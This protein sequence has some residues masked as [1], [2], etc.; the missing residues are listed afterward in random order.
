MFHV[1]G[2]IG[3]AVLSSTGQMTRLQAPALANIGTVSMLPN[4][5]NID[6]DLGA[7]ERLVTDLRT[8]LLTSE[9]VADRL[10]GLF[11]ILQNYANTMTADD[12]NAEKS[13]VTKTESGDTYSKDVS[14][15]DITN[16]V[17]NFKPTESLEDE[18]EK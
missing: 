9:D 12:T 10:E 6:L 5:Q 17:G 2:F 16:D 1:T 14:Y 3:V 15:E 4:L 13:I 18:G 8:R 11:V 7:V